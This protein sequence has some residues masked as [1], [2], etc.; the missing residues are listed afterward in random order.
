M[1]NGVPIA[2]VF[3]FILFYYF[4]FDFFQPKSWEIFGHINFG[5]NLNIFS[6]FGK[7]LSNFF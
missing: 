2:M 7:I 4:N 1:Q 6:I 5:V 3:Y